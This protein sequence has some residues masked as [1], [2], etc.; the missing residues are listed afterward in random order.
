[1]PSGQR[2]RFDL[3]RLCE[4]GIPGQPSRDQPF[5]AFALGF[6]SSRRL[7]ANWLRTEDVLHRRVV[8]VGRVLIKISIGDTT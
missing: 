6:A 1:M 4:V 2:G 5:A 8:D 7:A 3:P